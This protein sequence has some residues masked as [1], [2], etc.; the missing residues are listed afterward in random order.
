MITWKDDKTFVEGN[1]IFEVDSK[2]KDGSMVSHMIGFTDASMEKIYNETALIPLKPKEIEDVEI[3]EEVEPL[4]EKPKESE[5]FICQHCGRECK[6]NAGR[7]KHESNCP[8][9]PKNKKGD[10][11]G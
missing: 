7:V 6:T 5:K 1:R 9:N 3:T 10:I 2:N 4:V 11:D 8:E